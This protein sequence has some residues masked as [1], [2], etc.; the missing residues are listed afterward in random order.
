MRR[1]LVKDPNARM[2]FEEFFEHAWLREEEA[3]SLSELL[4]GEA[5]RGEL[6]RSLGASNK[7][8]AEKEFILGNCQSIMGYG[9]YEFVKGYIENNLTGWANLAR[10]VLDLRSPNPRL[11]FLA[12]A[13]LLENIDSALN[14]P[15][16]VLVNAGRLV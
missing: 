3:G 11:A 13:L 7:P 1:M 9:F 2:G 14:A 5:L 12:L 8:A 15:Y 16:A 6:L 4:R 10:H